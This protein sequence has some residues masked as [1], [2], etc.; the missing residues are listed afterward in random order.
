MK[1][2]L[3]LDYETDIEKVRKIIKKVG[4]EM[5]LDEE[6]GPSFILPLKSQG[7]MRVEESALIVRMKFTAKPGEQW[8]IRR[9]AY[10][11]VRDALAEAGIHFAHR[12]VRVRLPGEDAAGTPPPAPP[13]AGAEPAAAVDP[14]QDKNELIAEA[15]AAAASSVIASEALKKGK[16]DDMDDEM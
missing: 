15:A 14:E 12:E 11:R 8:V 3:R 5:L 4:Q 16:M 9:E 6:M 10:R 1:L 13:A 2:E 7:V